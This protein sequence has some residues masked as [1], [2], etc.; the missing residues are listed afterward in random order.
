LIG[1]NRLILF[2]PDWNPATDLQA[3]ARVWRDGQEQTVYI[4]RLLAT[5]S[6]DEKIFQR[7]LAKQEVSDAV[8]DERANAKRQFTK[9]NLRELFRL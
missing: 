1:G 6:I 4:Y 5:A 2:D 8:V 3:M 7:Q 9:K